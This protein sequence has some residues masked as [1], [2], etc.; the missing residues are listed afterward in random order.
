MGK[1]L[2][3]AAANLILAV[4]AT[5]VARI[6]SAILRDEF[7]D[8][9]AELE[10][11][12]LLRKDGQDFAAASL[13]DHND[14]PVS[15]TWSP[16]D[17]NW[18]YFSPSAGWVAVP[19]DR[20]T[21]Y[22]LNFDILLPR[23]VAELYAARTIPCTPIIPEHLWEMGDVKLPGRGQR[24]P[25]WIARRLTDRAIWASFTEAI[26]RRP[27]PGLR[28]VISLT[29]THR[30]EKDIHLGHSIIALRDVA[31]AADPL[32]VDP[33]ILAARVGG[34]ARHD[35]K[36]ISIG[37]E[38]AVVNVRGKIYRFTGVK[39]RGI[40]RC[41]HEAYDAGAPECVTSQVLEAAECGSSV[42]TLAKAFS[43]RTD[44]R[45]FIAEEGG[46]CWMFC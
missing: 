35:G 24:I 8:V 40:I 33:A 25:L 22:C 45:D 46:R 44:W 32:A 1:A 21:S 27:A 19:E 29:P 20:L 6:S 41:L 14:A 34:G 18:G 26:S 4:A 16:Q 15:V 12:A 5:P 3:R 36:L 37:A 43:G 7:E 42:N 10:D 39:Q 31:L 2:S 17:Q 9:A 30:L 23:V 38:G 28:I 11:N 13:A